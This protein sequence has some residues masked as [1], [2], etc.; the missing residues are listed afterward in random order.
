MAQGDKETDETAT[1]CH[2]RPLFF[3][4]G[5]VELKKRQKE[6]RKA[7]EHVWGPS[8]KTPRASAA[9]IPG[10]ATACDIFLRCK[11]MDHINNLAAH[12]ELAQPSTHERASLEPSRC[13][14]YFWLCRRRVTNLRQKVKDRER[15][16]QVL[17]DMCAAV[18]SS[19]R[20]HVRHVLVTALPPLRSACR[21]GRTRSAM[22]LAR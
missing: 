14:S 15:G 8:S 10:L 4:L 20:C 12:K 2:M 5:Q 1:G 18:G 22:H 16:R 13:S 7:I 11:E 3:L 9:W 17:Q 6:H 21:I 19:G